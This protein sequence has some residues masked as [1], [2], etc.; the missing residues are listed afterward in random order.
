MAYVFD[1]TV[2]ASLEDGDLISR[3]SDFKED[4]Q[5]EYYRGNDVS[6]S[7]P[8]SLDSALMPVS[9]SVNTKGALA[10]ISKLIKKSLERHQVEHAVRVARRKGVP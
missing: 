3:I 6:V 1:I 5:R 4:L 9:L 2:T 8:H 7:D 10:R